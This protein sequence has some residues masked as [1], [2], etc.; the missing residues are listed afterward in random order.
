MTNLTYS[1]ILLH[2]SFYHLSPSSSTFLEELFFWSCKEGIGK[3]M[4]GMKYIYNTLEEWVLR[5]KKYCRCTIWRAINNLREAGIVLF[6]Q[7]NKKNYDRTGYYSINWERLEQINQA[8]FKSALKNGKLGKLIC[9]GYPLQGLEEYKNEIL[10]VIVDICDQGGKKQLMRQNINLPNWVEAFVKGYEKPQSESKLDYKKPDKEQPMLKNEIK[11]PYFGKESPRNKTL[12]SRLSPMSQFIDGPWM[13][14]SEDKWGRTHQTISRPFYEWCEQDII[15]SMKVSKK[16]A[17]SIVLN[18]FKK[19]G[20]NLLIKWET[21]CGNIKDRALSIKS[22]I[23]AGGSVN[24]EE[25]GYIVRHCKALLAIPPEHQIITPEDDGLTYDS[26]QAVY[27]AFQLSST[28]EVPSLPKETR[29]VPTIVEDESVIVPCIEV[30]EAPVVFLRESVVEILSVGE[31]DKIVTHVAGFTSIGDLEN[32]QQSE[33]EVPPRSEQEI[34]LQRL[35]TLYEAGL[36]DEATYQQ[37]KQKLE[38][39]K[40]EGDGTQAELEKVMRQEPQADYS[41]LLQ[42]NRLLSKSNNIQKDFLTL[43]LSK[44]YPN[45]IYLMDSGKIKAIYP[46]HHG[47]TLIEMPLASDY[48]ELPLLNDFLV[49]CPRLQHFLSDHLQ[50]KYSSYTLKTKNE[51]LYNIQPPT[52]Q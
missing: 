21:Y 45:Y 4:N 27:S 20:T 26:P 14:K 10:A 32:K 35:T 49:N 5:I 3:E 6:Q 51:I 38:A 13:D 36:M 43:H 39:R 28:S 17:T 50:E 48:S 30:L 7:F 52:I 46:P 12:Q 29:L 15:N 16:E 44:K 22:R 41:E 8:Y 37:R 40:P 19:D 31:E 24:E 47:E 2:Q 33:I 18:M 11:D 23:D 34:Q 1:K 25:K 9:S 42:I